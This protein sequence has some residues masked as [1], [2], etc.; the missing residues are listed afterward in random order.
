MCFVQ[1]KFDSYP[2]ELLLSKLHFEFNYKDFRENYGAYVY[3]DLR[4][5][6]K[7]YISDFLKFS[8]FM[9]A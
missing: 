2:S 3:E 4:S 8:C 5:A 9:L 1:I 7:N 6:S